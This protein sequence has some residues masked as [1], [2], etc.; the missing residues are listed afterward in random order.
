MRH[1]IIFPMKKL[2]IGILAHVDAGK[3][4][5]TE[6][7]LYESGVI[8]KLGRVDS[9]DAYLDTESLEKS[10]GITIVSKQAVIERGDSRI[11]LIDTPGHLD[12]AAETERAIEVLDLAI[13][14]IS[15]PDGVTENGRTYFSLLE[16]YNVPVLVFVNKMDQTDKSHEDIMAE[17]QTLG[18]G[19]VNISNNKDSVI[20]DMASCSE[21]QMERYLNGED[22]ELDDFQADVASRNIMPVTFGSAL[23]L[24]GIEELLSAIDTFASPRNERDEFGAKVFKINRDSD[25]TR[26]CF[27][28]LTG[29]KLS[30]RDQI[31]EEKVSQIRLYSGG[32]YTAIPFAES[33]DVVALTGLNQTFAGQGLGCEVDSQ[34]KELKP[35]LRF[36]VNLPKEVSERTFLPKLKELEEEDP[37]LQV[38]WNEKK[39]TIEISVMGEL[40]LEILKAQIMD[41]TKKIKENIK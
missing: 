32:K 18:H 19:F 34:E 4:T 16:K 7:L 12:F 37:L 11:T 38:D 27:I 41:L 8:R 15:A 30:V 33:G 26:L 3:T 22:L 23:H 24:D 28:K 10:R 9:G 36:R 39:Q 5:L 35:V 1:V 2:T 20:E 21:K 14:L 31:G 6:A 29:G 17:L 25:G 40:Q 13:F